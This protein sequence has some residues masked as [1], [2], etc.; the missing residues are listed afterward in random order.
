MYFIKIQLMLQ[1]KDSGLSKYVIRKQE[2]FLNY[3]F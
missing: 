2:V 3:Y 1:K